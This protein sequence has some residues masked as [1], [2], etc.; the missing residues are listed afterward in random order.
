MREDTVIARKLFDLGL[1]RRMLHYVRPHVPWMGLSILLSAGTVFCTNLMPVLIQRAIDRYLAAAPAALTLDERGRGLAGLALLYLGLAGLAFLF[2]FSQSCVNAWMGQRVV[3]HLRR[4]VYAK[5]LRLPLRFFDHTPVGRLMTRV[6]SDVEA[7]QKALTDGAISLAADLVALAGIIGFMLY[8]NPVLALILFTAIPVLL[9]TLTVINGRMRKNHRE[10]RARQSALNAFLQEMIV[11]MQ[12]VQ[13]FNREGAARREFHDQNRALRDAGFRAVWWLSLFFPTVEILNALAVAI[14]LAAG[15]WLLLTGSGSVTLGVMVAFLYYIREFFRPIE[16]LSEKSN[17]LQSAMASSERIFQL[18]ETPETVSDPEPPAAL[19]SFRGEIHFEGVWFAYEAE[20]WVLRDVSF[21][22]RSGESLALVGA[23]GAGKTSVVSLLARFYDVQKGCVRVDGHDVRTLRQ[24]D[25][26]RRMGIV[27][28]D[29]FI[30]ADTIA[31]NIGLD[32][33][34]VTRPQIEQAARYVNADRFIQALPRGYDTV[35]Q[36]R[37][38]DLSTG[39]KQLLA[40]ARALAQNPDIL[41]ILDE[42]TAN[43]DTETEQLIQDALGKLMHGRTCIL[44]AHRLST[45]RHVDRILVMRHGEIVEQGSH[46]ELIQANGYY[47]RLYDLLAH[48]GA[49]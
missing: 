38:A 37:G 35:V 39:Q 11:G 33:P 18:M 17:N 44:I 28:Q 40:L 24:A 15:G 19:A 36:E 1:L 23:T 20:D 49:A 22:L 48:G 41:L 31:Y 2:R 29:P 16:D 3:F 10:I 34:S 42:A 14:L 12:T 6:T 5:I 43:V 9:V 25:L 45:I 47:R 21:H 30:F 27:L 8:L 13:L 46:P 26:R 7:M 32:N 4:D